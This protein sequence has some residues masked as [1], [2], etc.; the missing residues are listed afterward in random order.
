M[1]CPRNC[2]VELR[3]LTLPELDGA[4]IHLCPQCE[5]AWYPHGALTSVGQSSAQLL[6]GTD[7]SV[8]LV[9]DK[10]EHVDLEA[11]VGCPVCQQTM[12]RFS[13]SLAPEVKIDECFEHGTWLDD[14]ELGTIIESVAASREDLERYR[15]DISAMRQEMGMDGVARGATL[16]PFAATLRLLNWMFTKKTGA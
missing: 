3:P 12:S 13:Y 16:N 1:R 2:D 10:L 4:Q 5:G 15:Q 8:S 6:A 7:L 9:G 14:G 11:A